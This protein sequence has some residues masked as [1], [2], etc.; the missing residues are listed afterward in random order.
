MQGPTT[1]NPHTSQQFAQPNRGIYPVTTW[2][3]PSPWP[4]PAERPKSPIAGPGLFF[5][6]PI[7]LLSLVQIMHVRCI[8]FPIPIPMSCSKLSGGWEIMTLLMDPLSANQLTTSLCR[9][10][11]TNSR[12]TQGSGHIHK[13]HAEMTRPSPTNVAL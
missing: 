13:H 11:P 4:E 5:P 3:D 2:D 7:S 9:H 1:P 6:S 10:V 8:L 12:Q